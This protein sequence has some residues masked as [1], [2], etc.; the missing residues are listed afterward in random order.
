MDVNADK[1]RAERCNALA[2]E[3][4]A[5]LSKHAVVRHPKYGKIYAYEVDGYGNHMFMDD[6]NVPSLL[7][8]SYL[9]IIP[10]SDK[11]WKRTRKFVWSEDNPYFFRG[12][13]GR[14]CRV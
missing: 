4:E 12:S 10:E 3:V 1:N 6:A 11:I 2:D 7:S 14:W 13:C 5:A 8:M 9:G